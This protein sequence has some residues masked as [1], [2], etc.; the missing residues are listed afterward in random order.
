MGAKWISEYLS[1]LPGVAA[2]LAICLS[3]IEQAV[4]WVYLP[5]LLLLP[6]YFYFGKPPLN[7]AEYAIIPIGIG[8]CR[9][10]FS[11][12]W[13]WSPLDA[14]VSAFVVWNFISDYHAIGYTDILQRIAVPVTLALFPYM[15]GKM[16][17]EQR[18]V[19]VAFMRR[20]VFFLF[21]DCLISAYE[22]RMGTNPAR[23]FLV[24]YFPTTLWP[25]TVRE[26]FVRAAGP[27]G[28]AILMGTIV[29]IAIIMHRHVGYLGL[30]ERHFRLLPNFPVSKERLIM[31][32]GWPGV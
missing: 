21:L 28:H 20:F 26:G 17:I 23:T 14:L 22:F 5:I 30:W 6:N 9:R 31:I 29:G 32:G 8:I 2:F 24:Q 10:G 12:K 15:V 16:I 19:R 25:G 4:L 11:G 13:R 3:S 1:A 18:G 27:F 7:F